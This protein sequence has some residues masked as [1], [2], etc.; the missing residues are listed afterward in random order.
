MNFDDLSPQLRRSIESKLTRVGDCLVWSGLRSGRAGVKGCVNVRA[1]VFGEPLSPGDMLQSTCDTRLCFA[2]KH[3]RITRFAGERPKP[4]TTI[5]DAFAR[6]PIDKSAPGGCWLWID[7]TSE[8]YGSV[9]IGGKNSRAERAHR[10]SWMIHHGPI[11]NGLFVLHR[12]DVRRC[13]N[14]NHLFLGTHADNMAD[15]AAK[16]RMRNQYRRAH[17]EKFA[18]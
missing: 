14:P 16:G 18:L 8:G 10:L 12:C 6:H 11:P 4:F 1:L 5:E 3:Q 9:R 15:A 13:V 7:G 2:P 17:S